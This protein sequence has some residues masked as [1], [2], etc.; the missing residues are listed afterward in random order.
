MNPCIAVALSG[1]IDSLVAAHLL[2]QQDNNI[3][4][5]HFITGYEQGAGKRLFPIKSLDTPASPIMRKA[6]GDHPISHIAR[7]LNIPIYIIDCRNV[8]QNKVIDYFI[9][10]YADGKTPNPCMVCNPEIKFGAL[11]HAAGTLGATHLATGHYARIQK[12]ENGLFQL[13]KGADTEKEQSYFLAMLSQQQLSQALFPLGNMTKKTT[14]ELALKKGLSPVF[15]KESQD[16]CFIRAHHYTAFLR[17][18]HPTIFSEGPIVNTRGQ[19]IGRHKGLYHFT[20]GQRRG[21]N[22]PAAEPYYVLKIL[23]KEN[24]LLVGFKHDLYQQ[25]LTV[26]K[27]NWIAPP[28]SGP[29]KVKT[30]IRYRHQAASSTLIPN[31][32]DSAKIV[33]DTPQPAIAPGQAAVCYNHENIVCG[34]FIDG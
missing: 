23:I 20:V 28:S 25:E 4:G 17:E 10:E 2:K 33:F 27:I 12:S 31:G 29:I 32:K 7:Q 22:C 11:L 19:I 9:R 8:F 15:K 1:G 34:G 30:R 14:A 13:K 3:I 6:P 5:L 16:I 26:S 21:I 24:T 18:H